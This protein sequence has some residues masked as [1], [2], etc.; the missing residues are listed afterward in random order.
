M[1]GEL[2]KQGQQRNISFP[3]SSSGTILYYTDFIA[4]NKGLYAVECY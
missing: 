3:F 1:S 2:K 4:I